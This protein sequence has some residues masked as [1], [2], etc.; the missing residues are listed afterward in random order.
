MPEP[1]IVTPNSVSDPQGCLPATRQELANFNAASIAVQFLGSS[2][3]L[4]NRSVSTPAPEDND[5]IW[6]RLN[7]AGQLVGFY[8]FFNGAWRRWAP[9]PSGTVVMFS[10][11][12]SGLFSG[13]VG[14]AGTAADGYYLCDGTNG[15]PNL[16]DRFVVGSDTYSGGDWTTD[17]N[18]D[19][20]NDSAGG[21]AQT[22]L[23]INNL[24]PITVDIP[25]GSSTGS[26]NRFVWGANTNITDP[27]TLTV[28]AE[29]SNRPVPYSNLPPFYAL[30]YMMYKPI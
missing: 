4:L 19:N 18:P 1:I 11:S 9:Y 21:N 30:A 27:Y 7:T 15:T 8:Y 25:I 3:A 17:V 29:G 26:N 20:L 5:R 14:V 10:G 24:P 28:V 23:G 12:P 6:A 16:V 2:Y 22:T 13:S